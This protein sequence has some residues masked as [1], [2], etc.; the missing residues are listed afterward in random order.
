[1]TKNQTIKAISKYFTKP[2]QVVF[3]VLTYSSLGWADAY[4]L[5]NQWELAQERLK[6]LEQVQNPET[7]RF[8]ERLN[9]Q[10]GWQ[11]LDIGAG[12][13]GVAEWLADRVGD[14]GMVTATDIDISFLKEKRRPNL[15][16]LE[17]NIIQDP[18]QDAYD[19]IHARD[20]LMH[21][22]EKDKII[23][24]LVAALKPGGFLV[25]DDMAVFATDYRLS[26]LD[27]PPEVWQKEGND[28]QALEKSGNISFHSA[29][30]NHQLFRRAG[31]VN[32]QAELSGK[33]AQG[34]ESPEGRLMYLSTLQLETYQNKTPEEDKLYKG[35]LKAYQ[36]PK[37]YWWDHFK[38]I[39]WGQKK[40]L[41]KEDLPRQEGK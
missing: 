23:S 26:S 39:T 8:L 34:G 19:L 14:K 40:A 10:P 11:C 36:S 9:I 29:Y 37:S 41:V 3:F 7:F 4:I 6:L 13:G 16:V 35:I 12:T 15:K 24:K 5:A 17:H 18:L 28:Y 27:A 31:L 25:I 21:L 1:M 2:F 20:V 33:L 38:V 32:V 22:P 30:L